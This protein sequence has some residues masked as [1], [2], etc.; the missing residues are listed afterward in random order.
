MK[1][2]IIKS[3]LMGGLIIGATSCND[4]LDQTS[5]SEHDRTD[6]FD[7]PYYTGLA[8][9][10]VY[11]QLTEDAAYAQVMAFTVTANSDCEIID[12]IDA[13]ASSQTSSERGVMNY[14]AVAGGWSK[15]SDA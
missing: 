2:N 3:I 14:N 15:I 1:T 9:N 11:G 4:F 13:S 10:K 7:S 5:P 8:L 12:G 6:V